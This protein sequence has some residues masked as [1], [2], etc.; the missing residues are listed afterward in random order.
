MA[1]AA[2]QDAG[3]TTARAIAGIMQPVIAD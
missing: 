1:R 2:T 3:I